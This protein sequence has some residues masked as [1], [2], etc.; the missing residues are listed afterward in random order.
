MKVPPRAS[1][2]LDLNAEVLPLFSDLRSSLEKEVERLGKRIEQSAAR[3][4]AAEMAAFEWLHD[5]FV[6]RTV[7]DFADAFDTAWNAFRSDYVTA[8]DE[9]KALGEK[10]A[11]IKLDQEEQRRRVSLEGRLD[12]MREG[13]SDFYT[14]RYLATQGFLPNYAFPRRAASVFFNDRKETI[15]RG[16]AIALREFAPNNSIY[17]GGNRYN[18]N[19]AQVR[20]RGGVSVWD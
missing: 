18:V 16:R 15:S 13:R 6:R 3:A 4:F 9:L 8:R 2:V 7:Q 17:Y 20:A 19:R 12:D 10:G 14:F 5:D 1:E 11:S